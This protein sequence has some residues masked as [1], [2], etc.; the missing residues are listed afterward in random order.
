MPKIERLKVGQVLLREVSPRKWRASWVDPSSKRHMRRVLPA[1]TFKEAE[2]IARE[3]NEEI[4]S[5]KGFS[6]RLRGG[7]GLRSVEDAILEAV[8]HSDANERTRKDYLSRA[9]AFLGYLERNAPGVRA[10]AD[11][12]ASHVLNFV[13]ASKREGI[14]PLTLRHRLAVLRMTGAFMDRTYE[15]PNPLTK[16]RIKKSASTQHDSESEIVSPEEMRTLVSWLLENEPMVGTWA[17]VQALTGARVFEVAY[18]REKDFDRRARTIQ[19]VE[20]EAKAPKNA[21]SRRRIPVAPA[22]AAA[23]AAWIDSMKVRHNAGFLFFPTRAP[24]GRSGARSRESRVGALSQDRVKH[25]WR[26][27]L[28]R[29]RRA[30]VAVPPEFTP[31][32]LRA[33]FVTAMRTARADFEVLQ[34]YIG[35][36]PASI[37]SAHYDDV[38]KDRLE[39]IARLAQDL[40]EGKGAFADAS[41]ATGKNAGL[42]H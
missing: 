4:A 8:K 29:A 13:E 30:G 34:R 37:L 33:S 22:V 14:A 5:G 35:H 31:R 42:L 15:H 18:L 20:T 24:E 6:P 38:S 36:R 25:L 28:D 10:W 1:A 26:E 17:L 27:A 23:L 7:G 21:S 11:V 40:F 39:D 16:V 12:T 41:S 19:I 2:R 3:I 32:R 9:N